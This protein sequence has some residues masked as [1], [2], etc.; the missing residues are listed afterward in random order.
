MNFWLV[1]SAYQDSPTFPEMCNFLSSLMVSDPE[2]R[3]TSIEAL[4]HHWM[5]A[6]PYKEK[7]S[8]RRL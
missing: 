7:D 6:T 5:N 2:N 1:L 8:I 4:S 3:L